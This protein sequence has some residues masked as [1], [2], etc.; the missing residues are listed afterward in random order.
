MDK[1]YL[2]YLKYDY[3]ERIKT[4]DNSLR[5]NAEFLIKVVGKYH[6]LLSLSKQ[7]IYTNKRLKT[8]KSGHSK[9]QSTLKSFL[10]E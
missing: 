1:K 5:A 10:R 8:P 7:K 6:T 2:K 4:L 9:I 3:K